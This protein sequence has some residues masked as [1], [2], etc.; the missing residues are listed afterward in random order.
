MALPPPPG[1]PCSPPPVQDILGVGAWTLTMMFIAC[2]V[3]ILKIVFLGEKKAT[4]MGLQGRWIEDP[5]HSFP[6][7]GWLQG[8]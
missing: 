5:P 1:A 2:N 4:F 3:I 8:L 6:S 7:Q